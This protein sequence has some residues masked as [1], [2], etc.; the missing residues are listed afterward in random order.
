[1]QRQLKSCI[2]SNKVSR[3]RTHVNFSYATLRRKYGIRFVN[4]EVA[5]IDPVAKS[6][7]CTDR[8][9]LPYDRLILAPGIAFDYTGIPGMDAASQKLIPHA[10]KA[11]PQTNQLRSQL[12]NIV[13][14]SN[15]VLTIPKSPYRCPPGPYERACVIADWL[16]VNKPGSKVIV[17]D[18]SDPANHV[19]HQPGR[20]FANAT[21]SHS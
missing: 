10:W 6:V 14:G 7:T 19:S 8:T 11:G 1:M 20:N 2:M 21:I 9:V 15:F 5:A 18:G 3:Q 4:A 12:V 17:L 16:R 13:N